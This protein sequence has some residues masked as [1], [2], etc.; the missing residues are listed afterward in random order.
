MMKI[1]K[2]FLAKSTINDSFSVSKGLVIHGNIEG[3]VCGRI[4]GHVYGNIELEGKVIIAEDAF[5]S[6]YIVGTDININGTVKGNIICKGQLTVGEKGDISGEI[7]SVAISIHPNCKISGTIRKADSINEEDVNSVK[8]ST[9][10][11]I[12]A[13]L[14]AIVKDE[15]QTNSATGEA[16]W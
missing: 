8:I 15:N 2:H 11:K 10:P 5:V 9:L 12:N 7:L 3:S 16:W 13:S 4:E 6:G 14:K 1:S